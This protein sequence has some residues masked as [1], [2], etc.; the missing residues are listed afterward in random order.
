MPLAS[1]TSM[2]AME[3]KKREGKNEETSDILNVFSYS[4][5]LSVR[6]YR[7]RSGVELN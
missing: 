7:N 4:S 6:I 5:G 3:S 2:G 1:E